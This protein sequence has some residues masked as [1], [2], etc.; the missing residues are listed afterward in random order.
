MKK[1]GGVPSVFG[2]AVVPVPSAKGG[3]GS[4]GNPVP[5]GG[6]QTAHP[7][8]PVQFADVKGGDSGGKGFGPGG[9]K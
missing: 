1:F 7:I 3:A 9:K 2:D 4:F 6:K 5:E 8:K